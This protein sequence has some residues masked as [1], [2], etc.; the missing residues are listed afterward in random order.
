M[1]EKLN[2]LTTPYDDIPELDDDFFARADI[3]QG[4]KLIKRGRPRQAVHK[5]ATTL[6]LDNEVLDY[7]KAGGKG[8]QTRLNAALREYI[9]THPI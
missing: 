1:N 7:F 9:A 4:E 5:T 6:R 2:D 3:Y 8:W